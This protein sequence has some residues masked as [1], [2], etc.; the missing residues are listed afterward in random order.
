MSKPKM[1]HVK[2][3][4][5]DLVDYW[6]SEYYTGEEDDPYYKELIESVDIA[7][8]ALDDILEYAMAVHLRQCTVETMAG[9]K[10]WL[11]RFWFDKYEIRSDE[12]VKS[13]NDN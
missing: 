12:D 6:Y 11:Q 5:H 3:N 7:G 8:E 9:T 2:E 10:K 13:N 1:Q 4:L